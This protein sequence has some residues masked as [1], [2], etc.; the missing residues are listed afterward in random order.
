M[1]QPTSSLTFNQASALVDELR[2][3]SDAIIQRLT[4]AMDN[5]DHAA[6]ARGEIPGKEVSDQFIRIHE[7]YNKAYKEM[8]DE[9]KD[10]IKHSDAKT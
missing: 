2:L 4:L 5:G 9:L 3:I 7:Q 1:E 8:A 10:L 6:A